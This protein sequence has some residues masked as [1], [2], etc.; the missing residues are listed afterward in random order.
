MKM[1]ILSENMNITHPRLIVK[2]II[3]S[4]SLDI[5]HLL[6]MCFEMMRNLI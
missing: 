5:I 1:K 2:K 3:K 4:Q 6:I